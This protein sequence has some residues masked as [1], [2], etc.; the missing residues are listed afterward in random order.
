MNDGQRTRLDGSRNQ[1]VKNWQGSD[2]HQGSF[3]GKGP[4]GYKRSKDRIEEE[5]NELLTAHHEIDCEDV[6]IAVNESGE[7]T[8]TGTCCDRRT[9]RMI[10][11]VVE[12]VSG[13]RDIK[14]DLKVNSSD[15]KMSSKE[16]GSSGT[17]NSKSGDKATSH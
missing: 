14:N 6:S 4:K 2:Q 9:K 7:V 1:G 17:S 8:L 3:S 5:I 15:L 16:K 13:V 12:A 10:E 11:D